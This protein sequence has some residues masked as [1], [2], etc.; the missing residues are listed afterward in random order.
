[1][2]NFPS[3]I[4]PLGLRKV[5][6][7][8]PEARGK[9]AALPRKYLS[10][11]W[12]RY[13]RSHRCDSAVPNEDGPSLD[14]RRVRRHIDLGIPDDERG[15]VRRSI[16]RRHTHDRLL[17]RIDARSVRGS[18][19]LVSEQGT[20]RSPRSRFEQLHLDRPAI[21]LEQGLTPPAN[22][23]NN[24]SRVTRFHFRSHLI[25]IHSTMDSGEPS[26][27]SSLAVDAKTRY[28]RRS[29]TA[30]TGCSGEPRWQSLFGP[31]EYSQY[32][33]VLDPSAPIR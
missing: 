25:Q 3:G 13:L 15:P 18:F 20:S 1:M 8:I 12:D 6:V 30:D 4:S 5:D 26:G 9:N 17:G 16:F 7:S 24:P 27:T 33:F 21:D 28:A 23:S 31:C 11:R 32:W 29:N 10:L 14:R 22:P 19:R 2:G